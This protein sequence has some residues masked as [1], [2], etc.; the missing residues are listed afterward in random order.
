MRKALFFI[1]LCIF[2]QFLFSQKKEASYADL[3]TTVYSLEKKELTASAL[4]II[5]QI[6]D[7]AKKNNNQNEIVKS[8]LFSSKYIVVLEEDAPLTI[9]NNF[10]NEIKNAQSPAKNILESY[11]ATIYWQYFKKN[12]Y[13]FYNRTNTKEKVDTTDFRT[14][15]LATLIN[16]VEIHFE[17]SLN[18]PDRLQ[19]ESLNSFTALLNEQADS[20]TFRPTLYDLLAHTALAFY[21]ADIPSIVKPINSFAISN[22]QFL[23][24]ASTFIDA[25]IN[26]IDSISHQLYALK[27]Y[28][29][30]LSFHSKYEI[31]QAFVLVDI[32]RLNYV[33]T[34]STL[35]DKETLFSAVLET[36]ETKL[37][38]ANLSALYGYERAKLLHKKGSEYSLEHPKN[39]WCLK[40]AF[41]ICSRILET[42]PNSRA[43]KLSGKLK[44]KITIK[45]VQITA[46]SYIPT[47]KPARLLVHYKNIDTLALEAYKITQDQ[48]KTLRNL[49]PA[50]KKRDFIVALEKVANWNV[51]LINKGD[52]QA[53]SIEI[54]I[55]SLSNNSYIILARPEDNMQ[56]Q[57]AFSTVHVTDIALVETKTDDKHIFQVI[58]RN[59]GKPL[60]R[61]SI[62]LHFRKNYNN[63]TETKNLITNNLGYATIP[64]SDTYKSVAYI[65][66]AHNDAFAYFDNYYI[67]K[68]RENSSP[69]TTYQ[70]SL[71]QDR[72][73]YRP[74]QPVYF[75]GILVSN[76]NEYASVATAQKLS[77][78][79]YDVNNQLLT[80]MLLETNDFGSFTGEFMLPTN[81]LTGQFYIRTQGISSNFTNTS[82]FSVEEYKRPKFETS[83]LP[84]TGSFKVNDS[85]S[86]VGN[87]AAY[88]GNAISNA[89]VQYTIKRQ[90]N[91]PKWSYNRRPIQVENQQEIAHGEAITD[92]RGNFN[93]VFDALP[94]STI[95]A[96]TRPVF[97]YTINASVTDTKGETQSTTT[98]VSVGYH[99]LDLSILANKIWSTEEKSISLKLNAKNLNG[100]HLAKKASVVIQKLKAPKYVLRERPW[101]APDYQYWSKTAFQSLYPHDA[102]KK[103]D[104]PVH[105]EKGITVWKDSIITT[106]NEDIKINSIKDWEL[107]LYLITATAI[108]ISG[109]SVTTQTTVTI[110]NPTHKYLADNVLFDIKTNAPTYAI[111]DV[112]EITLLSN[113]QNLFISTWL[114]KD[115]SFSNEKVLHLKSNNTTLKVPVTAKD[116][117]GFI[118]HYSF[119]FSNNFY[120]GSQ[121][122]TVPYPV[123]DLQIETST[124]RNKIEPNIRER[125]S[126]KIKRKDGKKLSAE[127][128][129]SM[130][131]ASLDLFKPH[132]WNFNPSLPSK[133][134][135][136]SS[137]NAYS[138]FGITSFQV[139]NN[140][141]HYFNNSPMH[142]DAFEW[143][144]FNLT[145]PGYTQLSYLE[146]K[147]VEEKN[148]TYYSASIPK[149][150]VQGIVYDAT[151][152]PIKGALIKSNIEDT[153][154]DVNGFFKI[155]ATQVTTLKISALD[156]NL[157]KQELGI[158]N[159]L[160]VYLYKGEAL[161]ETLESFEYSTLGR[162]TRTMKRG[163]VMNS[164]SKTFD[165]EMDEDSAI[166]MSDSKG[167]SQTS[168]GTTTIEYYAALP[169]E[170][171]PLFVLDGKVVLE[172]NDFDLSEIASTVFLDS[173][174]ALKI[175]SDKAKNGVL[176]IISKNRLKQQL[177]LLTT[178]KTRENMQETAFFFP[179]LRTNKEGE[180]SFSFNT[181]EA[182]TRWNV[183]LLAHTRDLKATP[184]L[185]STVTEKKLIVQ[186]NMPRFLRSGDTIVVRSSIS[187]FA[188]TT[189]KGFAQLQFTDIRTGKNIDSLFINTSNVKEFSVGVKESALVSWKIYIPHTIQGIHYKIIAKAG[190][191]SDGEKN[192]IPILSNRILVTETLPMWISGNNPKIFTL[193]KLK[194]NTSTTLRSHKLSLEVTSNSA[195]YA[196]K[197]LPYLMEKVNSSNEQL[198][199]NYYANTLANFISTTNPKIKDVFTAWAANSDLDSDLEKNEDLKSSSIENTPWLQEEISDSEQKKRIGLLFDSNTTKTALRNSL[200]KLKKNQ[201]PSGGWSWFEGGRENRYITQHIITNLA[202]LRHFTNSNPS[203]NKNDTIE[204]ELIDKALYYLDSVFIKTHENIKKQGSAVSKNYLDPTQIQYLYMRSFFSTYKFSPQLAKIINFYQ[205]Q[206]KE[207]WTTQDLYS[208]GLIALIVHRNGDATTAQEILK[209]LKENSI[210]SDE[211][212]MYWKENTTSW[213]WY[214]SPI[215]TQALL[216]EAFSEIGSNSVVLDNMKLWLLKNKETNNWGTTK[217]TTEAIYALLQQGTDWVS[218]TDNISVKIG[219]YSIGPSRLD[220]ASIQAGSGYYKTSWDASTITPEMATVTLT[221]SEDGAAWGALYWQ[222]Y[223]DL[224][225]I[226]AA[227]NPLQLKK[228]SFLKKD[229]DKGEQL[230]SITD[231]TEIPLGAT[232]RV[233]IELRTDRTISFLH[234]KDMRAAGLE[235][236]DVISKY[237][238]QDGLGYYQSTKDAYTDF[239]FDTLK[240]GIYVFEYDVIATSTGIFNT[241][242]TTIQ[243]MYAPSFNS[244]SNSGKITIE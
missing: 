52:F 97:R 119:S 94:D 188:E 210:V 47:N 211:L 18:N 151:G 27:L 11:L 90:A 146:R 231:K 140:V 41:T 76:N 192:F 164:S 202:H 156:Y 179:Q 145:N 25:P 16:E 38:D 226:T 126:F 29:N 180:V 181:P 172:L 82:Y 100:Q 160:E 150:E 170:E 39:Q 204:K 157:N 21:K 155:S 102:Y 64:L 127:L 125:W 54:P 56:K 233:K 89:K 214:Q 224:D 184:K 73:I 35:Q 70:S 96:E 213:H 58:N 81:V 114:E 49:Y 236:I 109:E 142:F 42:A 229:T 186:P 98:T 183:Q 91:Y 137:T 85:I 133:Y 24:D 219:N 191:S 93:I 241:G 148:K 17:N 113:A 196:I 234:M 185:L 158:D 132:S 30:L 166:A 86:I 206:I 63:P 10:K 28:Q 134:R 14:W 123:S 199:S 238:W 99:S 101:K 147:K 189:L 143:F 129:A 205:Y 243:S 124:F 239:Y 69:E 67:S 13:T 203:L 95:A 36:M 7:K 79:L 222:Y 3:W 121:F 190:N 167:L 65:E 176:Q 111:G 201:L 207:F 59:T 135:S 118:L 84:I 115:K 232:V 227:R 80:E 221:K 116:L 44:N 138:S 152:K 26:S 163:M 128:L 34:H 159:Y 74:G 175:Y 212:G 223:E 197:A 87:A 60:N 45:N 162:N 37:K 216:I 71:F 193:E 225:K 173:M 218:S 83:F 168:L 237:K 220:A 198:F 46:E 92:D 141:S 20:K 217:A 66:V 171:Q 208:K 8:L 187:N 77:V 1:I 40:D 165:E 169:T 174:E 51:S 139:Q 48:E 22:P 57:F 12:S 215:A 72:S 154:T 32:E 62:A 117:G 149:N 6:Y 61:A 31:E 200:Q 33:Y 153:F 228:N 130:Y 131:D 23:Q 2:S 120:S 19:K 5:D 104:N 110:K 9:I 161:I 88:T 55:P 43:A 240:K 230:V 194:T 68:K 4:K 75:K 178:V 144:G 244:H 195:W 235:P 242:I 53:H 122:I 112:A 103:E 209:S 182:L 105:W 108:D 177:A 78:Q 136:T 107:G 50:S 106:K 15:D